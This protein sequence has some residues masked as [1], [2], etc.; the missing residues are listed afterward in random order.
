MVTNLES[1][2]KQRKELR[3]EWKQDVENLANTHA[4]IDKIKSIIDSKNIEFVE[5]NID[6]VD[7]ENMAK[8]LEGNAWY[9]CGDTSLLLQCGN[10]VIK[11]HSYIYE[12]IYEDFTTSTEILLKGECLLG[13]ESY[14][15]A[16]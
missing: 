16:A 9:R 6:C 13:K 15:S 3:N 2:S 10:D 7:F 14:S 4:E 5:M 1:K 12:P 11:L 8:V